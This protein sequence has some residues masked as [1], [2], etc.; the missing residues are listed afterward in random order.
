MRN[1]APTRQ[2]TSQKETHRLFRFVTSGPNI[3]SHVDESA[4]FAR[5]NDFVCFLLEHFLNSQRCKFSPHNHFPFLNHGTK[6]LVVRWYS[7]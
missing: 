6:A 5:F 2:A 1:M 4:S 3:R 7:R